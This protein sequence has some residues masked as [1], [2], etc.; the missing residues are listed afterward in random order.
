M[1]IFSALGIAFLLEPEWLFPFTAFLLAVT[2]GVMGIEAWRRGVYKP[3][4][5]GVLA[6]AGI[7]LGKFQLESNVVMYGSMA[8]LILASI[9]NVL[10][11]RRPKE[12]NNE[13]AKESN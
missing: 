5:L 11:V 3:L 1:G 7:L 6:A 4:I 9:W 10:P 12:M 13:R 8:V 2:L